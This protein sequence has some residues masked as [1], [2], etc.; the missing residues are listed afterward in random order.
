MANFEHPLNLIVPEVPF[1][2]SGGGVDR[3]DEAPKA[4]TLPGTRLPP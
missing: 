4:D 1:A 2:D 3:P